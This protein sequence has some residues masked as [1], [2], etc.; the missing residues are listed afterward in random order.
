M[1]RRTF[2][3]SGAAV[4]AGTAV[5]GAPA[6]VRAQATRVL[7]F[8]PEADV[9]IF[10]PI[11]T[12]S[13]QTRDHA[14]LVYDTLFGLD[15]QY[16]PQPQMLEGY[17]VSNDGLTWTLTLRD[18]LRFHDNEPVRAQD[19]AAS[20]RRW[21][22]RDSFGQALMAA[23]NEV[24]ATNDRTVTVRLK[25][26]FPM[27]PDAL[28]KTMVY[29][30]MVMPERLAKLDAFKAVPEI[31]GSGPYRFVQSERV[32][33]ARLVYERFAGYVPRKQGTPAVSAGPK[34]AHFDRVEWSIIQDTATAA[35]ALQRGELDWL[36][37]PHADLIPVLRKNKNIEVRVILPTGVVAYMRFN[38]LTPPFNNAAIRRA[39]LGAVTQSD[40]MIA[41]NGP[42]KTLWRD[43]VGYFVPGSPFESDAGMEKL[44]SKRDL[45][46]VRKDLAA[47]GYKGE[48]VVMLVA[49]DIPY[50]KI[51]GEVT[52][53][54]FK[55]IG[56]NVDYQAIDWTTVV[57]R[58]IR[59]DP[60]EQGGWNLFCI[61]DSG[62]NQ[63][64]PASHALLRGN[65]KAAQFGWPSSPRIE[66]LREAW[67]Q[68]ATLEEQKTIARRIQVQAFEDVPY[69][70]LGQSVPPTAYRRSL[71]GVLN[72]QPFF[73]NVRRAT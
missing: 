70:P 26:P 34:V 8:S 58:R 40:Y 60:A 5:L 52:A 37:T 64:N 6:I 1:K 16:R 59:M 28:A 57:Q 13:W 2:L 73:W 15:D 46:K 24:A 42:D 12:P 21:G 14:F 11:V 56:I 23:A 35:A 66:E 44:T 71:T 29:P 38:H 47:A 17:N 48:R 53:D 32:P 67:F 39:L 55:R 45:A 68:A 61:Y 41:I 50:L 4:A 63:L 25:R 9:V 54:L 65:G 31:I 3:A 69:I 10:D 43:R 49:V 36:Q 7:R 27:L 62:Y 22:I 33:G 51:M 72:G 20:I 18:G 30:C 19:A